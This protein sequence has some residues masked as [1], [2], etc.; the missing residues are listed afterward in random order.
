[1]AP[2]YD[3]MKEPENCDYSSNTDVLLVREILPL[4]SLS[5]L[6]L[7]LQAFRIMYMEMFCVI[8]EIN[9]ASLSQLQ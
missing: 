5:A 7:E 4:S 6:S 9:Y 2:P 8:K 1:M 3:Q